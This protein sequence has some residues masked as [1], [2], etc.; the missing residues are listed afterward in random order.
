MKCELVDVFSTK[1][2]NGNGLTIFSDVDH[3]SSA[4]MLAWTQEMR[5]FESIF[6]QVKGGEFHARIFTIEEE[7]DF[8]G[9]PLLGLAYHL[10]HHYG[11]G[12]RHE[13]RVHTKSKVIPLTSLKTADTFSAIYMAQL[14]DSVGLFCICDFWYASEYAIRC[15]LSYP[16]IALP[17]TGHCHDFLKLPKAREGLRPYL[18]YYLLCISAINTAR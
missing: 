8:A 5:Q 6:I 1:K 4:D 17:W 11:N 18:S 12:P 3:L 15:W 7:L 9:H 2:L 13:W 14:I 10:H 16:L